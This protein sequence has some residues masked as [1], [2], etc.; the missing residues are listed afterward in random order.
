MLAYEHCIATFDCG[1]DA[2]RAQLAEIVGTKATVSW[3]GFIGPDDPTKCAFTVSVTGDPYRGEESSVNTTEVPLPMPQAAS[4]LEK[5]SS[6]ILAGDPDPVRSGVWL[7]AATVSCAVARIESMFAHR[8]GCGWRQFWPE[9]T[10]K[11]QRV[12]DAVQ[13]SWQAGGAKILVPPMESPKL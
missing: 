2:P 3:D 7:V 10:L 11:T 8:V 6:N 1:F 4:L 9:I 12:V 13:K 5:L